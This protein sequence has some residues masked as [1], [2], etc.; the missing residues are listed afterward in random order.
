MIVHL[1][2]PKDIISEYISFKIHFIFLEKYICYFSENT[3]D[4]IVHLSYPEGMIPESG[5]FGRHLTMQGAPA[6]LTIPLILPALLQPKS[7]NNN[8]KPNHMK[9]N[10]TKSNQIKLH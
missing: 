8:T 9:K 1:S 3:F 5:A 6:W 2:Y 10:W 7:K 4:M